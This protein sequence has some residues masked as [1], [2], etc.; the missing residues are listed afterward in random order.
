MPAVA[1]KLRP[2]ETH[3]LSWMAKGKRMS[4]ISQIIGSKVRTIE[5]HLQ[6]ARWKLEATNVTHA[7]ALA[8]RQQLI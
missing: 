2:R 5:F 1:V 3:C 7:V 8:V 4:E 6:N